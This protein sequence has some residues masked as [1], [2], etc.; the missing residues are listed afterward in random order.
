MA[1]RSRTMQTI[2][3][4]SLDPEVQRFMREAGA[5]KI[6]LAVI[7]D[8]QPVAVVQPGG[9]KT[10]LA[11][12]RRRG[13]PLRT[14]ILIAVGMLLVI[15]VFMVLWTFPANIGSDDAGLS[16]SLSIAW[17]RGLD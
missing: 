8:G 16:S 12:H 10:G 1:Q 4:S 13:P 17:M 15:V 14:G 7:E 3:L 11:R 9:G 5:G 6:H 2:P